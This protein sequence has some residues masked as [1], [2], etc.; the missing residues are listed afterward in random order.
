MDA[1]PG[2]EQQNRGSRTLGPSQGSSQGLKAAGLNRGGL[3]SLRGCDNARV[4]SFCR[5]P[6]TEMHAQ[7]DPEP[8]CKTWVPKTTPIHSLPGSE[9]RNPKEASLAEV[10]AGSAALT[11]EALGENVFLS[12]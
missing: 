5:D 4:P 1:S 3:W 7:G 11:P 9:G 6:L 8:F 2:E 10:R 12:Q